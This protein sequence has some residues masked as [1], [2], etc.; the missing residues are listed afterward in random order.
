MIAKRGSTDDIQR[1]ADKNSTEGIHIIR[2]LIGTPNE[3][4][5]RGGKSL[6]STGDMRGAGHFMNVVE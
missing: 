1:D 5:H 3:K 6:D 4:S 2:N